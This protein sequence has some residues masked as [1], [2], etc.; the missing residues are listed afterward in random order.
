MLEV[1][2]FS[3]QDRRFQSMLGRNAENDINDIRKA[4]EIIRNIR[5]NRQKALLEKLPL[6]GGNTDNTLPCRVEKDDFEKAKK[7]VSD[8]FL[9]ALSLARVNARKFHESQRRSTYMEHCKDGAI[10]THQIR[11]IHRIGIYCGTSFSSLIAHAVPAQLAGVDSIAVA[12]A[13]QR[14]QNAADPELNDDIDPRILVAAH[15]F[16]IH[17]VYRLQGAHAVAAFAL[18]TETIEKTDKIYGAD[19]NLAGAAKQLLST[20]ADCNQGLGQGDLAIIADNSANAKFVAGDMLA[21]AEIRNIGGTGIAA[22]FTTDR[23]FGEAVRIET[24]RLA[25]SFQNAE[26]L[27]DTMNRHGAI[28]LCRSLDDALKAVNALAPARLSLHT[29]NNDECLAE[30]DNAGAVYVGQWSSEAAGGCFSGVNSLLP[31]G[32][33]AR[34][35][36]GLRIEDFTREVPIVEFGPDRLMRTGRH[37]A[38]LAEEE[39]LPVL[40][41]T[42]RTRLELLK[43]TVD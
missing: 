18:G 12:A 35:K 1:R 10:I 34:F 43:L 41:Q 9:T 37:Q 14:S 40:A 6:Y 42:V 20:T 19:D 27:C 23:L 13:P 32:G 15:V 25:Q 36:S 5:I 26:E 17:E 8:S 21:Q 28:F 7:Q 3:R 24:Q 38:I 29:R 4:A 16:G 22:L 11:P 30:V 31:T 33:C 39:G 2:L